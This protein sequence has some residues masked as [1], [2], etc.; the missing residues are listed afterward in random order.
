M[1][2]TKLTSE[3]CRVW[4]VPEYILATVGSVLGYVVGG[5]DGAILG[6]VLGFFAGKTAQSLTWTLRDQ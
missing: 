5:P 4:R 1:E 6:G 2:T 3:L